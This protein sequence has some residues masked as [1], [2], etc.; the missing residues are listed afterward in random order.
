[1]NIE[2]K[3]LEKILCQHKYV[4]MYDSNLN[5]IYEELD[6]NYVVKITYPTYPKS[7]M[8]IIVH[9]FALDRNYKDIST[10]SLDFIIGLFKDRFSEYYNKENT[11]K[12]LKEEECKLEEEDII[13]VFDNFDKLK[14]N[15][16]PIFEMLFNMSN[17]YI[18][19]NSHSD[20]FSYNIQNYIVSNFHILNKSKR[21]FI[22]IK[23][24]VFI[25][26]AL[27]LGAIYLAIAYSLTPTL[28]P[29]IVL[30]AVWIAMSWYKFENYQFKEK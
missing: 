15:A 19:A 8:K 1:M 3:N 6:H 14:P 22:Y 4:L 30:G 17:V 2:T 5:M 16:L 27:L 20:E 11:Q 29:F 13:L 12:K 21:K 28:T 23:Q 24:P 26:V 10:K 9:Y 18:L 25:S 7:I